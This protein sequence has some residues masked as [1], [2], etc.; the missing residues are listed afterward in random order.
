MSKN[1]LKEA[2]AD[3]KAIKETAIENAKS[4]LE[5]SFAPH[6]KSMLSAR[7]QQLDETE[8][9]DADDVNEENDPNEMDLEEILRELEGLE[10]SDDDFMNEAEEKEDKKKDD[11]KKDDKKDE[12]KDKKEDKKEDKEE[13]FDIEDMTPEDLK[14]FIEDVI[15]DMKAA[16]ELEAGHG[17][18]GEEEM[19]MDMDI[20]GGAGDDMG[21]GDDMD[22][23]MDLEEPVD[24]EFN[25]DEL[26]AEMEDE[27]LNEEEDEEEELEEGLYISTNEAYRIINSVL[28]EASKKDAKKK[29][30]KELKKKSK[31]EDDKEKEELK[32]MKSKVNELNVELNEVNLLNAKLLYSNKIFKSKNLTEGEK[33]KVL[34]TF[35]KATTVKE[36]KLVFETLNE[37]FV[38]KS[39]TKPQPLKESMGSAS[40]AMGS[41]QTAK[42]PIIET[43]DTF[44]RMQKLAG[45][46]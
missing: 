3:A 1:L 4:A 40:K 10:E 14:S 37:G 5:E 26:L 22:L 39:S 44:A 13:S 7:L 19:D 20:E 38:R 42:R 33:V 27:F 34:N 28:S 8:D 46:K 25:I 29:A 41:T 30:K 31:K 12:K 35:D 18:N 21:M 24:E 15:E 11:K 23:G 45:L 2:I 6:L 16:G 9:M 36:V 17:A 32:E 43:N